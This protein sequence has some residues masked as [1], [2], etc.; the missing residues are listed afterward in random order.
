M[1]LTCAADGK[2]QVFV[3][4]DWLRPLDSRVAIDW[5]RAL[6]TDV[7][8][9]RLYAYKDRITVH[10][11]GGA[12][13]GAINGLSQNSTSVAINRLSTCPN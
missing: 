5:L 9:N 12:G 7:T 13:I 2:F 4:L 3:A 10:G 8:V 1:S 6:N 11:R